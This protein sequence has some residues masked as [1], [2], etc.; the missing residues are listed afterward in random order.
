MKYLKQYEFWKFSKKSNK[1]PIHHGGILKLIEKI[2]EILNKFYPDLN[3]ITDS[4]YKKDKIGDD[5]QIFT[6]SHDEAITHHSKKIV[7]ASGD[8]YS[9]SYTSHQEYLI[10]QITCNSISFDIDVAQTICYNKIVAEEFVKYLKE[11]LVKFSI[12]IKK[13]KESAFRINVGKTIMFSDF[14]K[15]HPTFIFL[16]ERIPEIIEEFNNNDFEIYMS[17]NKYNL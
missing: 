5:V 13:D 7:N 16:Y 3:I 9:D 12:Y 2:V 8:G 1:T 17:A 14:D 15:N 4:Q 6:I 10:I 11:M